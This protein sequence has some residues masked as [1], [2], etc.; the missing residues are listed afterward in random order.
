MTARE[1]IQ[2]VIF[3]L[4]GVMLMLLKKNYDG[5]YQEI[6]NS[7]LGNLSISF[8]MYFLISLNHTIWKS[9]KIITF[10]VSLAIVELFEITDGF[11]IM[12]NVYDSYDLIA[13][14]IGISIALAFDISI[15]RF[16]P[17]ISRHLLTSNRS[18]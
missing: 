15:K 14:L 1:K 18:F 11:G 8:S 10:L 2:N 12:S 7:Y 3:I 13:N 4:I 9:K 6:I 16:S 17:K 5:P